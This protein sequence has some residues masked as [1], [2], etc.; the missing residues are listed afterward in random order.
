M[1]SL[2]KLAVGGLCALT[3]LVSLS[4]SADSPRMKNRIGFYVGLDDPNPSLLSLNA[5]YNITDFLRASVGY[6]SLSTTV[7]VESSVKTFGFG[8]KA[9]YPG[10]E[11]SPAIGLNFATVSYTGSAL[12]VGGF[13]QS[14]SHL[15]TS[16]GADWQIDSGLNLGLGYNISFKSG[17]GGSFYANLGWFFDWI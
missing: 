5:A 8:L 2:N 13:T 1:K 6:G 12:S 14:G 7:I 9:L 15:Y 17:V 10:W 16:I 3:L 4:A 11:L